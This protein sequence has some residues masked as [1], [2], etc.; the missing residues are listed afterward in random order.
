MATFADVYRVA[1]GEVGYVE[2]GGLGGHSGNLTKY[3]DELDKPLS[4]QSWCAVFVSWVFKH[5]G[6]PLPRMDRPYGYMNCASAVAYARAH[7]LFDAS[8]HYSPGDIVLF[9]PGGATHTGIV[10]A[11]DGKTI[12]TIEGNT[13]PDGASGSQSNGGG[14]YVRHRP[15]GDWVYGVLKASRFLS[16]V[17]PDVAKPAPSP[18]HNVAPVVSRGQTR[19]V[20]ALFPAFPGVMHLGSRGESVR[21]LQARLV[22]RG[23]KV[24]VDGLF[25]PSTDGVVRAFQREKRLGVDGT[26]GPLTWRA[27][28]LEKVT[29]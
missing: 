26:V 24:R 23:W 15:H 18:R 1:S 4:G 25:G 8:G 12:T 7:G 17:S 11:D 6:A 2:G 22:A 13:V 29:K 28:W 19:P 20:K 21:A 3:W 10:I 16:A 14:V 9:G 5:A 27:L